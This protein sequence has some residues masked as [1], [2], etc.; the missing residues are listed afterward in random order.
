MW[1]PPPPPP[2]PPP[3]PQLPRLGVEGIVQPFWSADGARLLYYDQPAPGQGGT[4]S[5][6][7]ATGAIARERPEWGYYVAQGTLVAAARPAQRDTNV[8][9][10]PSG[11]EWT[12]PT[13][14]ST[15][16]SDDGTVVAYTGAAIGQPGGPPPSPG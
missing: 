13:T 11:R 14:N 6:D 9:H 7:P 16:F 10:L 3:A 12:L 4:W 2:A 5:A 1:P 15:V 8:L